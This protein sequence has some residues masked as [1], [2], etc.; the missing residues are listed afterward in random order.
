MENSTF[1]LVLTDE[2]KQFIQNLLK[3]D[4]EKIIVSIALGKRFI[5]F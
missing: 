3:D 5:Y 2:G 1:K 4:K